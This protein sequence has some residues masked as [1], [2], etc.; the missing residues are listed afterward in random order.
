MSCR[1]EVTPSHERL[2]AEDLLVTPLK[3]DVALS[4]DENSPQCTKST[5]SHNCEDWRFL[6]PPLLAILTPAWCVLQHFFGRLDW[7]TLLL[8]LGCLWIACKLE[9]CRLSLPA[10]HAVASL[11]APV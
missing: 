3:P 1:E 9:E 4:S 7:T 10:A 11:I 6:S 5:N 2:G 8:L